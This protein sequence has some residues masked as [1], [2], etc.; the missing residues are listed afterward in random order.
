[1]H[2]KALD[3][4]LFLVLILVTN[5]MFLCFILV[6]IALQNIEFFISLNKAFSNSLFESVLNLIL[7]SITGSIS[8]IVRTDLLYIFFSVSVY[9]LMI[10]VII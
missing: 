7:K 2:I 10:V 8:P 3:T 6:C 9:L 4:R 1:M 5:H